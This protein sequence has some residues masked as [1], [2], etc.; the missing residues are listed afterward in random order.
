MLHA[1]TFYQYFGIMTSILYLHLHCD[2]AAHEG[3]K[4]EGKDE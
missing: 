1:I 2:N 3:S 4:N